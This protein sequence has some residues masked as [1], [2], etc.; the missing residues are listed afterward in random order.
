MDRQE[1]LSYCRSYH[2]QINLPKRGLSLRSYKVSGL[3]SL[4]NKS[5]LL[6]L[7]ASNKCMECRYA[8]VAE[9][10]KP[11]SGLSTKSW[12]VIAAAAVGTVVTWIIVKPAFCDGSA[13]TRGIC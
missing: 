11:G 4:S 8:D 12:I 2:R 3:R 10:K 6:L 7:L 9:V 13:Q 1:C 5:G